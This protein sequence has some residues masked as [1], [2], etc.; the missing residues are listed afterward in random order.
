MK[1]IL[2]T[3]VPNLGRA[4]DE[5]TVKDGYARNFLIPKNLVMSANARSKKE[6]VFLQKVKERKLQK[7]QKTAEETAQKITGT[8][9]NL[10]VKVGE[11]G[12]LFGSVTNFHIQKEL[13]KQGIIVDKK[14]I[15]LDSPIRDLGHYDVTI[16]FYEGIQSQIKVIVQDAEGHTS[17]SELQKEDLQPAVE[18]Q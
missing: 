16:K 17:V 1:V 3:D 10:V 18:E 8:T 5:K 12:K 4:G 11:E 9:V 2:K 15:Q 13:E 14:F 6:V 7:R